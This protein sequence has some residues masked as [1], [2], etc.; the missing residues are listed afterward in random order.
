LDSTLLQQALDVVQKTTFELFDQTQIGPEANLPTQARR[1]NSAN[2]MNELVPDPQQSSS[3]SLG[4][5]Q[6]RATATKKVE[7]SN[8]PE[9]GRV[10]QRAVH[11]AR[12]KSR[13]H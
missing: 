1:E 8:R 5:R 3:S 9:S 10:C 13:A 7:V 6:R 11:A 2:Q 12:I 4:K